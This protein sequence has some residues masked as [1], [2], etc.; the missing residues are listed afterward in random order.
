MTQRKKLIAGNWKM[1]K[2]RK[3]ASDFFE[4]FSELIA[5]SP[6]ILQK[7]D[8]ALAVAAPLLDST[9]STLSSLSKQS[10]KVLAQNCHNEL[11]GAFTGEISSL[12]LRE[13]C[14]Q[15]SL[16]GHSERRQYF[17]E[18]SEAVGK[19]WNT[20][21][22]QG[23]LPVVCI[24]ETK[25]ERLAGKTTNIVRGQLT[26]SFAQL[27]KEAIEQD[28]VIAYE[29]VWAIGTGLTATPAE[30]Q[31]V[32]KEIR[33][34]LSQNIGSARSSK[35]RILYGGS[36]NAQNALE[37]LSQPDIDGGLIGGASLKPDDFASIVKAAA[38]LA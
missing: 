33:D 1:N 18:T 28:F 15:G 31:Q 20:L 22:S 19:K 37:L 16:I 3:E 34:W 35:V 38:T 8:V 7:V 2:T 30:A 4:R 25:E 27:S 29:P 14:A 9:L 12:M 11:Q 5:T 13:L 24:G 21:V 32:H 10:V 26:T 36:M 17:N 23:L 6:S